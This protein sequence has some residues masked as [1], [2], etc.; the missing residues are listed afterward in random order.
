VHCIAPV[1]VCVCDLCV[2]PVLVRSMFDFQ[3]VSLVNYRI[4][5]IYNHIYKT[6]G[7]CMAQMHTSQ[8]DGSMFMQEMVTLRNRSVLRQNVHTADNSTLPIFLTTGAARSEVGGSCQRM[9]FWTDLVRI[10][11]QRHT[12]Y[13]HTHRV[14]CCSGT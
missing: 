10:S 5:Y 1:C 8:D 13:S 14:M 7:T 6:H 4:V 12:S 11:A 3:S 9:S 2:H